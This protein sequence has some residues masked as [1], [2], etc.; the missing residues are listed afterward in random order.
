MLISDRPVGQ[1]CPR[2]GKETIVLHGNSTYVCLDRQCGFRHDVSD[3]V[4]RGG[5]LGGFLGTVL[6]ITVVVALL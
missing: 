4:S 5:A 1:V 2:C 3:D 6:G